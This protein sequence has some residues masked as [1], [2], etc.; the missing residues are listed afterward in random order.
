MADAEETLAVCGERR[1]TRKETL[2]RV[3]RLAN[4]LRGL[5][6]GGNDSIA[7]MAYNSNEFLEALLA[8]SILGARISPI[9][10][11]LG[12][13]ELAYTLG[14]KFNPKVLILDEEFLPPIDEIRAEVGN[15]E[16]FIALGDKPQSGLLSYENLLTKS[17]P[18]KPEDTVFRFGYSMFVADRRGSLKSLDAYLMAN[19][20]LYFLADFGPFLPSFNLHLY[21][22]NVGLIAT[23]IYH[24]S[25]LVIAFFTT[26]IVGGSLVYM[27]KFD[28]EEFLRLIE[29]ER[30]NATFIV[31]TLLHRILSLPQEV[32]SKYDLSSMRNLICLPSPVS[33][34]KEVNEFFIRQGARRAVYYETYASPESGFISLLEPEHYVE[35]PKRYQSVG[36]TIGS[37]GKVKIID[38]ERGRECGSNEP[39]TL[40]THTWLHPYTSIKE[41]EEIRSSF[42]EIGGE[43]YFNEEITAWLDDDGFLYI[44]GWRGDM[45]YSGGVSIPATEVE[46][47]IL[48]HPK[49][50]DVAVVGIPD[51]EWGESVMAVVQLKEGEMATSEEIIDFAKERLSPYKKPK[52]VRFIDQLPMDYEG[53][54]SKKG[55]RQKFS[56]RG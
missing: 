32:K 17:S 38:E 41:G 49:V 22:R 8:A 47:A 53:R 23:P 34:K 7:F 52:L 51:P 54:V 10:W 13:K 16:Y 36:K 46:A 35:N 25:A 19:L 50:E 15:I 1:Y 44:R 40:F 48:E 14:P 2:E 56:A 39:G 12:E 26:L 6:I 37:W 9:Y 30:V 55:L 11:H 33:L 4:G 20:P 45:V 21:D 31:P 42:R 27:R 29:K 3:Y 5:G 18:Q 43:I 28:A 24:G